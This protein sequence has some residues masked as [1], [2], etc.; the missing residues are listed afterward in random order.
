M[1]A[2]I[3]VRFSLFS[4]STHSENWILLALT[5]YK[6]KILEDPIERDPPFGTP[7]FCRTKVL[8]DIFNCSNFEWSV[9]SCLKVD[10]GERKKKKKKTNKKNVKQEQYSIQ[11]GVNE[12]NQKK[13]G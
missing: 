5:I 8:P 1:A 3:F 4:L 10:S 11:V 12:H 7:N 2:P 13:G 9:F 6:F